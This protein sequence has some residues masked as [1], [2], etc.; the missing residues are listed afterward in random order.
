MGT[1]PAPYVVRQNRRDTA[2]TV[3]LALAPTHGPP[4][5]FLPGQFDMLY[6][7]GVGDVAISVSG[8]S[9]DGLLHTVRAVGAV[10]E[11]ICAAPEGTVL[12]VR[13][14]YGRGWDLASLA[15]L[16]VLVVAGGLG[17][18][19][20]R[21]AIRRLLERRADYGR[22][23]VV[24]GARTAEALLYVDEIHA[25]ANRGD[26]EVFVTVDRAGPDWRGNVGL[27]TDVLPDAHLDGGRTGALLCGP[28]VMMGHTAAALVENGF[29]PGRIQLSLERNMRCAV[30]QCGHCQMG[31]V[32][33]CR[34]GPVLTWDVTGPLLAVREL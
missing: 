26:V 25:W 34:D 5:T 33:L 8:R 16:D 31:P 3:T 30:A 20:L 15:G 18:A 27:V 17:L 14:P 10:T 1:E 12:G 6:A 2:D 23:V 21:E 24:V 22:F 32:L 4:L 29:H 9:A 7:F 19:P 11:A 13:G 28:E